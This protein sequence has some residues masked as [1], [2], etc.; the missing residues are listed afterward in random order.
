MLYKS[1]YQIGWQKAKWETEKR[2]PE[3]RTGNEKTRKTRLLEPRKLVIK[4]NKNRL[5]Y[6]KKSI[7][8][9]WVDELVRED[10]TTTENS[11]TKNI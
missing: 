3:I 5:A 2:W 7:S 9:A 6:I 1:K 10:E 4:N 11:H 8:G